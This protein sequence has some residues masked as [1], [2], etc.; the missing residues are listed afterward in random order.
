VLEKL[1]ADVANDPG[2]EGA[3]FE[4]VKLLLLNGSIDDAK[5]AF[6]PVIAQTAAVRRFD[7]LKRWMDAIDFVASHAH[8]KGFIAL[9]MPKLSKISVILR[10]DST[11]PAC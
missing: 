8:E 3:R 4:L 7:S 1:K 9:L 11:K 10:P 6:A 2:N 5:V